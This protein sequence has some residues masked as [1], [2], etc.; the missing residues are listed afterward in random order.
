MA[1]KAKSGKPPA[2]AELKAKPGKP[3]TKAKLKAKPKAKPAGRPPYKCETTDEPGVCLRFDR[4]PKTGRY[5]QPPEG[6]RMSCK[7]C[8]YFFD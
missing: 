4:D 7:D 3:P 8:E 6:I 1:K 5:N 2:K